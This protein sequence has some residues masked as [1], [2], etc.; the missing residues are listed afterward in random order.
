MSG[1]GTPAVPQLGT[2]QWSPLGLSPAH[3]LTYLTL[4]TKEF[5]EQRASGCND[6]GGVVRQA[7]QHVHDEPNLLPLFDAQPLSVG[8]KVKVSGQ[9]HVAQ[10]L[11]PRKKM[12]L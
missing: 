1:R 8:N 4:V 6:C 2:A 3:L 12:N 11:S 5:R 9:V 10:D 7:A